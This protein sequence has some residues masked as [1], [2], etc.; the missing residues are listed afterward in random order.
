M[1]RTTIKSLA[2][3]A[4]LTLVSYLHAADKDP[5]PPTPAE[6][7]SLALADKIDEL[8]AAKWKSKDITPAAAT[9]DAEFLRRTYLDLTGRIPPIMEVSDFLS[10]KA[11]DKRQQ[12]VKRL[13]AS[14]A[15]A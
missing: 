12:L 1:H 11:M 7:D 2:V 4:I 8:I 15:Y 5:V 9:D 10:I 6:R 3:A 14:G 13:L